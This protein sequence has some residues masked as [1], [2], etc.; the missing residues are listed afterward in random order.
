[1]VKPKFLIVD[2]NS[3]LNRAFYGYPQFINSSGLCVNGVYGFIN[4]LEKHIDDFKP[5]HIAV[6]FDLPKPT[7]RH[8]MY[9]E[10]KGTRG[11]KPPGVTDNFEPLINTLTAMG[12]Y[13]VGIPGYEGDDVI[14]SIAAN[15]DKDV[16]I[17]ILSGDKDIFQLID[18]R[19]KV[20][21]P[22]TVAGEK[23][24]IIYDEHLF[25]KEYGIDPIQLI[26]L[27]ALMGDTADNIPGV[28]GIGPKTATKII[29]EYGNIE[30]AYAHADEIKP[31]KYGKLLKENYESAKF[32][33]ILATICTNIKDTKFNLDEFKL[34]KIWTNDA[35]KL[36][37]TYEIKNKIWSLKK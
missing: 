23:K 14:G 27:K 2:G 29:K 15:T 24:T 34:E 5:S 37:D 22:K 6:A 18:N 26:D 20:R 16:E 19:T 4:I 9:E 30:N 33:K 12:I 8:E 35:L 7:F 36:L 21:F 31:A 13:C 28:S 1:M 3:I 11:E 25:K 17:N 32:S 10:Y